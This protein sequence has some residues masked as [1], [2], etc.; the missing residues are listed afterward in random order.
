MRL[1]RIS[2]LLFFWLTVCT[3]FSI[4]AE[5][6]CN[7][8]MISSTPT[9]QF[10]DNEDG[11]VTDTATGLMWKRCLE[12]YTYSGG[13][14]SGTLKT[15][16]WEGALSLVTTDIGFADHTDWRLPNIKEL[17]SIVEEQCYQPAVNLELFP[18]TPA[19]EIWSNSPWAGSPTSDVWIIHFNQGDMIFGAKSASYNVRFVRDAS[20]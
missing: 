17:Q 15:V 19:T 12:G 13:V 2:F 5:Q 10:T 3:P 11:T 14:C 18:N 16:N 4:Y 8:S 7:S 9:D 6:T 20:N 1:Y